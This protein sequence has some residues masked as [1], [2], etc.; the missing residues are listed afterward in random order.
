VKQLK[1]ISY[2]LLC[3]FGGVFLSFIGISTWRAGFVEVTSKNFPRSHYIACPENQ[4]FVYYLYIAVPTFLGLFIIVVSG[5]MFFYIIFSKSPK[6]IEAIEDISNISIND[7]T[8]LPWW[9][10]VIVLA[11]FIGFIIHVAI[12]RT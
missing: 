10:V 7:G 8:K 2:T 12:S 1:A 4:S 9:V 5:Y 3:F 6:K 11:S